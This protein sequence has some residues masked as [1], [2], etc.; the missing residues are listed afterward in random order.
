MQPLIK[1][2]QDYAQGR[3]GADNPFL[4]FSAYVLEAKEAG[5]DVSPLA[6]VWES[7]RDSRR[8]KPGVFKRWPPN[9]LGLWTKKSTSHD[10]ICGGIGPMSHLFDAGTTMQEIID[11]GLT[12][13]LY[14]SGQWTKKWY[15][16]D[17]EWFV[18]WRP[19]FR[20]FMKLAAGRQITTLERWAMKLNIMWSRDVNMT[21]V[22]LLFLKNVG[23]QPYFVQTALE[24]LDFKKLKQYHS[25]NELM[26]E[27]WQLQGLDV[28]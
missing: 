20:A 15:L 7:V 13:G 19:E 21:R 24:D 25:K 18:Y 27:L 28:A 5:L 17:T 10:E 11:E 22:K 26:H 23:F 2:I 4:N 1:Q 16:P 6:D 9:S 8:F 3:F 14:F 12:M